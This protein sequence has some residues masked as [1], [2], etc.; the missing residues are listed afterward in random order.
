MAYQDGSS[1][2]AKVSHREAIYSNLLESAQ[3][4]ATALHRFGVTPAD[5][6]N[7]VSSPDH[8]T[9][10]LTFNPVPCSKHWNSCWNTISMRS[11]NRRRVH[12][13]L[14]SRANLWRLYNV[15][16]KI[17]QSQ[18]SQTITGHSSTL[19][20]TRPSE[21]QELRPPPSLVS[22]TLQFLH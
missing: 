18:N 7:V 5:P 2:D 9:F 6:S 10:V 11:C 15:S 20:T 4:V 8:G 12:S 13:P 22:S 14:P 1:Y 21:Y 17:K 19:R 16:G 3:A